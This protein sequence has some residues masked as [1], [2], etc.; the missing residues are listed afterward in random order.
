MK[1]LNIIE[2]YQEYP[3][4]LVEVSI[5]RTIQQYIKSK[6]AA[7]RGK[8]AALEKFPLLHRYWATCSRE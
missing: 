6:Q 4:V 5:K 7:L 2:H 3:S 1:T 8:V